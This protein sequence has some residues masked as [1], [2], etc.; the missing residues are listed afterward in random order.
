MARTMVVSGSASGIGAATSRLLTERGD[1]V[2][3]VDLRD[4]DV[5][6]DLSQ[7]AGRQEAV[8]KVLQ[9]ADGVVDAVI[10]SAGVSGVSPAVL[11]VNYFGAT[12]LLEALRPALAE[13]AQPRAAVV[14]SM[15]IA[16]PTD[17]AVVE[18]CL[19]GDEDQAQAAAQAA[20]DSGRGTLL[21][22]SSKA[23]LVRWMRSVCLQ[24][25]WAGAGI[26]INAVGPGVVLTAMTEGLFDD[27]R[28]VAAMDAAVPM[29]LG[30]HARPEVVAE[31]LV[32]LTS[33]ANTHVTGQVLYVDGGA[34]VA[35]RGAARF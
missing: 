24:P 22:P 14:A 2:I 1:R 17:A 23:A 20:I 19:A 9:L 29:P 30:G 13:A 34:E 12:T 33:P 26:P 11:A 3:G 7:P 10:L 5:V 32:W 18:A 4:A 16:H 21:Y 31:A 8:E 35:V 27:P 28:M 6:A 25:D 15:T